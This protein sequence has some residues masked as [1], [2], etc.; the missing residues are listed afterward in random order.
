MKGWQD[1]FRAFWPVVAVLAGGLV[2]YGTLRAEVS[3][4][5][6]DQAVVK[7]DHDLIVRIDEQ[8]K[9][10]KEDIASIKDDVKAI[11]RAVRGRE[12]TDR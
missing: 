8:Q 11:A 12:R 10:M 1:T 3:Q 4:L 6:E 9:T 5:K 7:S 2:A